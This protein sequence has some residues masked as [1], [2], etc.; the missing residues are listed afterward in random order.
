M[1][2]RA[3]PLPAGNNAVIC[4][5]EFVVK[6]SILRTA[7]VASSHRLLAATLIYDTHPNY[8]EDKGNSLSSHFG[9]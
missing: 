9:V 5:K 8:F 2:A 7:I 6:P 4:V 3:Q 1:T